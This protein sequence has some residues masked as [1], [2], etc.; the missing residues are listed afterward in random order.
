MRAALALS[1]FRSASLLPNGL[2]FFLGCA[3]VSVST[4]Y[5]KSEEV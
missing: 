1:A 3:S 2:L 5:S 4:T